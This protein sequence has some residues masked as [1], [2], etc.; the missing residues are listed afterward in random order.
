[1]KVKI[2]FKSGREITLRGVK[3]V[4]IK[5]NST[6]ITSFNLKYTRLGNILVFLGFIDKLFISSINLQSI[7]YIIARK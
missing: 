5:Y 7:D 6:Q 1:M 3:D 2:G 4:E